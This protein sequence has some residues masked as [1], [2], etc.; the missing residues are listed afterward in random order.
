MSKA[1]AFQ[2]YAQDF[3]MDTATWENEEIGAYLRLLLYE[4]VNGGIPDDIKSIAKIVRTPVSKRNYDRFATNLRRN[5]LPK[6]T[7]NGNGLLINKRLEEVRENQI[8]YSESQKELA[9]RRWHKEDA[10]ADAKAYA[11]GMP[12]DIPNACSSSS[13][14]KNKY[15]EGSVELNLASF[16]LTEIQKNK[17]DFKQP[18]L[19][20]WAKEVDLMIRID[21]REPERIREVIAWAQ[22]DSFW[23]KNILSTNSLREKFDQL[24]LKMG[25]KNG[26]STW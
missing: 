11:N 23:K 25:T 17:P 8:K 16:L 13:S 4:W 3:D 9:N 20:G 7:R 14:S 10:M 18:N 26:K 6:F 22:G 5:V 19:Q 2:L 1:P 21:H 15:L 24:E 12:T